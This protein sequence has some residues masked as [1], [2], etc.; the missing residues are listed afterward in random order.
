MLQKRLFALL[1]SLCVVNPDFLGKTN[2]TNTVRTSERA[3]V[4][5]VRTAWILPSRCGI[6]LSHDGESVSSPPTI[7]PSGNWKARSW[8]FAGASFI[9]EEARWQEGISRTDRS[10]V[11]NAYFTN[12]TLPQHEWLGG[13]RRWEICKITRKPLLLPNKTIAGWWSVD[14]RAGWPSGQVDATLIWVWDKMRQSGQDRAKSC[15]L[16][17]LRPGPSNL[18]P[19]DDVYV[20]KPLFSTPSLIVTVDLNMFACL[21]VNCQFVARVLEQLKS[22]EGPFSGKDFPKHNLE[23]GGLE[24]FYSTAWN[25]YYSIVLSRVSRHSCPLKIWIDHYHPVI[26]ILKEACQI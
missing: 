17:P 13:C 16:Q 19:A 26:S 21:T 22:K 8:S 25:R 1:A 2:K 3:E 6:Y 5:Q 4:L 12:T 20:C 10:P 14:M 9:M 18:L 7:L 23:C 11:P 15:L 24:C